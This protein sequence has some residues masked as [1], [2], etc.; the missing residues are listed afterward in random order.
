M[1]LLV[2]NTRMVKYESYGQGGAAKRDYRSGVIILFF[3]CLAVMI[4]ARLFKLQVLDYQYYLSLASDQHEIFKQLYP[5]RGEIYLNDRE[6]QIVKDGHRYYPVA[7][8]KTLYLLY[9]LPRDIKDPDAVLQAL[10]EVFRLEPIKSD[11]PVTAEKSGVSVSTVLIDEDPQ[12]VIDGWNLKLRKKDDPYEPLK[13]L[14]GEKEIRQI[15]AY[16][17]EGVGW[18]KEIARFYPEKS[19][20]SQLLGFVGKQAEKNILKGY[21][22][23]E[24]C[25]DKEL[26][27]EAG[28]LHS[29]TDTLGRWIALAGKDFRPA[30]DGQSFVLTIDKSIQY[31]ACNELNKTVKEFS[32]ESGSLIAMDPATGSILAM[33]N[34]PDFDPNEYNKIKDMN[35][36][37]NL[38]I[39]DNYEPGSVYKPIT[40]AMALN[41]GV[42]D[43][44]SGYNDT[45]QVVF[46]KHTIRNSDLKAHGWQTMTNVLEFSLNT[47][48]VYVARKVGIDDFKRYSQEFGFGKQTGIDLCSESEGSLKS[49]DEKGEIYLATASFG[50]G[51]TT[52]PIQLLRAY[53]AIVND[54]KLMQP[55]VI[56]SVLDADGKVVKKNEP[57]IVSQVISPESAKLLSSMLVSVVQN[58][59]TKKAQIPG[60]LVGGK[61]GT[62]EIYDPVNGG[63]LHDINIHTFIGFAPFYKPRF[64]I[65]SKIDKPK[66]AQ[67]AESTAAPLFVKV[68]KFILDYYGVPPEVK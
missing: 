68:G 10:K 26:A 22:G 24:G 62:A 63:Y 67:Y 46:G 30:E 59:H 54:G 21:Y 49:L 31:F 15:E 51:I 7:L 6:G 4:I 20:G 39:A 41:A 1:T 5:V 11:K 47:G 38:S 27:G 65:I 34:A 33:C 18:S 2:K 53:G 58:G 60:Y 50:Q 35:L 29:E 32:A 37:R 25:Y 19:I 23:V 28:F 56:D 16:N 3:I 43:P 48:A 8:N 57:R 36:F 64:V 61:T 42:V 44:F 17:L 55:Y 66:N 40:M 12:G 52:T 14:V 45:G 13:H 9:A